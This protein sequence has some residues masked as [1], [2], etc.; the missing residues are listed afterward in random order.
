M[1]DRTDPDFSPRDESREDPALSRLANATWWVSTPCGLA[2]PY[3]TQTAA[4]SAGDPLRFP[5]VRRLGSA[6]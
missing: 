5:V 2:G 4:H 1:I 3:P 6:S